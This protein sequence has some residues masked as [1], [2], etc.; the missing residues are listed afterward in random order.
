[1]KTSVAQARIA[2][3]DVG[4][5]DVGQVVA[6]PLTVGRLVL[7]AAHLDLS[8]GAVGLRG[9]QVTVGLR[10]LLEWEVNV[11]ILGLPKT[12]DGTIDL[13]DEQIT[14][15]L[16]DVG[17]P[18]LETFALDL[19]EVAVEDVSAVVGPLA[20]L[21]LG[22]LTLEQVMATA[23]V[24]PVPDGALSGLEVGAARV[25]GLGVPGAT[26]DSVRV[27]RVHGQ[28][29]PLGTV[30]LPALALPQADVAEV[31]AAGADAEGTSRPF[32]FVADAGVLRTTLRVVPRARLHADEV[33]I[34][35]LT[36]SGSVGA[37]ELTDVVLP[38]ELLDLT[39][40]QLGISSVEIPTI[41][42]S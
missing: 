19:P 9:V 33:T 31:R 40:S 35:G 18:G 27:A 29:F 28:A 11:T 8:S 2:R 25:T 4:E 22:P 37:V 15:D 20:G 32:D 7:Q 10:M 1:M 12:W 23:L 30:T 5:V 41:E 21:R 24:A 17:L 39:L 34:S 38:Y 14:I 3:V 16:G 13:K 6:G 42:V 36:S 26:T